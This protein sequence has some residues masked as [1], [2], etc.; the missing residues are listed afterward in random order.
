VADRSH[1]ASQLEIPKAGLGAAEL[2]WLI[3]RSGPIANVEAHVVRANDQFLAPE[4]SDGKL[5]HWSDGSG[6]MSGV[7]A[8]AQLK[9][10]S[11]RCEVM[12]TAQ[13]DALRQR[14]T[15]SALG[16]PWGADFDEV[17]RV[18]VLRR[19]ATQLPLSTE[20]VEALAGDDAEEREEVS[21]EPLE[22][23]SR[24]GSSGASPFL[25]G[26][27]A[28]YYHGGVPGLVKGGVLRPRLLRPRRL[29]K[30][31][32]EEDRVY[33][34]RDIGYAR[35]FASAYGL[36]DLYQVQP[37][38]RTTRAIDASPSWACEEALVID[39]VERG[40]PTV[41]RERLDLVLARAE[42][43]G[44]PEAQYREELDRMMR[45][46]IRVACGLPLQPHPSR[47]PR[48]FGIEREAVA[49]WLERIG[50]PMAR[51]VAGDTCASRGA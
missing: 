16:R 34:T 28:A 36:G 13:V 11:S 44:T 43:A 14:S 30:V 33:V 5:E 46:R 22:S 49:K 20:I 48:E 47:P 39:V 12:T 21:V 29:D 9:D 50:S 45:D 8:V 1:S 18:A 24:L 40:V 19:L 31:N 26:G 7:Y 4:G 23:S 10:G 32:L 41:S 25:I 42:M 37:Y 2:I 35:C 15:S 51:H 3:M 17:A 38:G 27:G 6:A